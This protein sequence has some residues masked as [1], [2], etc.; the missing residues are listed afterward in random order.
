MIVMA[1]SAAERQR[2]ECRPSG[3]FVSARQAEVAALEA[4]YG[5][6]FEV[7]SPSEWRVDLAAP[8]GAPASQPP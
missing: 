1:S 6:E 5:E 8:P 4:I 7:L 3:Q 2:Q